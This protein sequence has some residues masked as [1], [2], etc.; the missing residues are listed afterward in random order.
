[1]RVPVEQLVIEEEFRAAG[2]SQA[3]LQHHGLGHSHTRPARHRGAG[4]AVGSSRRW[5]R[6]L[7]WCQ[8]FSEPEAGSDAAGVKTRAT[9]VDG[10]W[11]LNGQKVWTSGAHLAALRHGNRADQSGRTEASGHHHHGGRHEGAGSDGSGPLRM[12]SGRSEFNEVF[13]D[14]YFVPDDDVVGPDRWR[15]DRRDAPR[16]AMKA[17]ASAGD[18]ERC[19]CRWRCSST[20]S[21]RTRIGY[22]GVRAASEPS[23]RSLGGVSGP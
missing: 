22:A 20:R 2:I 6:K 9:K 14:D 12:T 17:S 15:L 18:R 11:L 5:T 13:F 23:H 16:S 19:R 7:I 10:G 4:V 8:L 3:E 1:M 21:T